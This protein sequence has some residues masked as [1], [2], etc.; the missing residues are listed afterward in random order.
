MAPQVLGKYIL[1]TSAH[2]DAI[3]CLAFSIKVEYIAIGRLDG[4]LQIF[5]LVDG[6]L[7]YTMVAPSPIKSL[8]W[9]PG[10]EQTLVCGCQSG[11]LI[12]IIIRA[13]VS[14]LLRPHRIL[15][16]HYIRRI[17]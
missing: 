5:N 4:K 15:V 11:I 9:L 3:T 14:N 2:D 12:N 8:I 13:G 10:A 16:M 17:P 1:S 6:Q 7:H